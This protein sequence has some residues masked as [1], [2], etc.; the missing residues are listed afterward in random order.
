MD[1]ADCAC[2]LC[3]QPAP[4]VFA[5]MQDGLKLGQWALGCWNTVEAQPGLYRGTS[6][7]D[8]QETW[9]RIEAVPSLRVISYHVGATSDALHPRIMANVI[10][11]ETLGHPAGSSVLSLFAWRDASMDD[12][13]W[14]QLRECHRVELR[15][16]RNLL[17]TQ[18]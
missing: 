6:I 9:V 3:D 4:V 16:I 12:D 10:P 17:R 2:I 15:V 5:F 1:G 14:Q 11:G 8:Q 18:A 13:R 7:I